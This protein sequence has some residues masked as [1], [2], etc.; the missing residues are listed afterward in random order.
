MRFGKKH[1]KYRIIEAKPNDQ[2]A[3]CTLGLYKEDQVQGLWSK[4]K[5][6]GTGENHQGCQERIFIGNKLLGRFNF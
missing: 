1:G 6:D 3:A 4:Y 5:N 2:E